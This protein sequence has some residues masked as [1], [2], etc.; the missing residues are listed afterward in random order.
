MWQTLIDD[1]NTPTF[2]I[3][4][5]ALDNSDAASPYIRAAA[6]TYPALIDHGHHVAALYNF[7]NVPEAVW[8]DESGRIVRPAETAGAYEAFRFIDPERKAPTAEASAKKAAARDLYL[9]ALRDWVKFGSDSQYA[10]TADTVRSHLSR[11]TPKLSLAHVYFRLSCY[12]QAKGRETEATRYMAEASR[13]HPDSWAIWRQAAP[14]NA[15]GLAA[16]Q[17]FFD[18]VA[19]LGEKRY[20]PAAP[21]DGMP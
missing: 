18:R 13:L 21:M 14:K 8:I 12:L 2:T 6:P 15:I 9:D 4:A 16:D 10:M 11:P 19:A 17:S 3:L 7:K 5:I 20:Y 1:L